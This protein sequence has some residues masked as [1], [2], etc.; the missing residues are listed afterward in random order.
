[1]PP[2][3]AE[4]SRVSREWERVQSGLLVIYGSQLLMRMAQILMLLSLRHYLN[5]NLPTGG[6]MELCRK[7]FK[8]K[9][10]CQIQRK[11]SLKGSKTQPL[12]FYSPTLNDDQTFT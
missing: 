12:Q 1:V 9:I 2:L 6:C 7:D 5:C 3:Q 11:L 8:L 10:H 4:K